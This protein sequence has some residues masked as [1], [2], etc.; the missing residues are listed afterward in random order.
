LISFQWS[1]FILLFLPLLSYESG[2]T[3]SWLLSS[4]SFYLVLYSTIPG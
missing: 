1:I 3:S 2:K 4:L